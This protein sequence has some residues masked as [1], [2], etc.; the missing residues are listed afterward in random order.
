MNTH[1]SII[2]QD[3]IR[4]TLN[5]FAKYFLDHI[6]DHNLIFICVV[7]NVKYQSKFDNIR[8][9]NATKLKR[10]HALLLRTLQREKSV[11]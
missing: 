3:N 4:T 6:Y 7:R 2:D 8:N 11:F 1:S 9:L 10:L 5:I